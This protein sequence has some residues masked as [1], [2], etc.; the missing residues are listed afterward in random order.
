MQKIASDFL[1]FPSD[2]TMK[3]AELLYNKGYISYPR[4]ETNSFKKFT[5][6]TKLVEIH[7]DHELLGEYAN[8]ILNSKIYPP[9]EGDKND[10]SHPPIY[11]AKALPKDLDQLITKEE[12]LLYELIA[13]CFLASCSRDAYATEKQFDVEI[14]GEQFY[15]KDLQ[16]KEHN[17]LKIYPYDQWHETAK[18][19]EPFTIGQILEN[20][21]L[22][23]KEGKTFPPKL[24]NE[25][26]LIDL[27]DI[28]GIGT[29]STIHEHIKKIQDREY[30]IKIQNE[31][32][33]S[34][35]GF[36]L[37]ETY[38]QMGLEIAKPNLRS[39]MEKEFKLVA[40]GVAEKDKILKK[41]L[42]EFEEIY[43]KLEEKKANFG[44]IFLK[45]FNENNLKLKTKPK[46]IKK[47]KY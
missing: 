11:P 17:F 35:L 44:E 47:K 32:H 1:N 2:Q 42:L 40:D 15:F 38:Q 41:S 26:E 33:P 5:N 27:M 12:I 25:S 36:S 18:I 9:R 24:L 43:K 10:N 37:I 13:R 3:T 6:F 22:A 19:T 14:E 46:F 21:K 28:N 45:Q 30:A 29:D 20:L 4:T 31:F 39:I 23:I 7:K 16:I 8:S 34:A